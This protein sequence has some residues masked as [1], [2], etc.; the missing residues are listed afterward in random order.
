MKFDQRPASYI[1]NKMIWLNEESFAKFDA[2][3]W[4]TP[5]TKED[6]DNIYFGTKV[7]EHP[8]TKELYRMRKI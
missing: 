3:G 4:F 7:C 1:V 2:A 5:A 8:V 6:V